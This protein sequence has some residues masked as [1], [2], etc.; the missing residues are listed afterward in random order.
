MDFISHLIE[1]N[2]AKAIAI[3]QVLVKNEDQLYNIRQEQKEIEKK[4]KYVSSILDSWS[5]FL[6][7][8]WKY[9]GNKLLSLDSSSKSSETQEHNNTED[10][11]FLD[12]YPPKNED[13]PYLD[14]LA[15]LRNITQNIS[16]NLDKQNDLLVDL[17]NKNNVLENQI[18][19]NQGKINSIFKKL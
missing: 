4:N 9:S 3:N 6:N 16:H 7:R 10:L 19:E 5:G 11:I 14:Q 13:T 1:Q 8:I 2:T 12:N 15:P 17:K 18:M